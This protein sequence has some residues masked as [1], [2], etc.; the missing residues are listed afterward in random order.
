MIPF[1]RILLAGGT[2]ASAV[3]IGFVM[4]NFSP[5][6]PGSA[7]VQTAV[8][9]Q[10]VT[11]GVAVSTMIGN[12]AAMRPVIDATHTADPMDVTDIELT[13]GDLPE[14]KPVTG[15]GE[16]PV[17]LATLEN[18]ADQL[19]AAPSSLVATCDATMEAAPT[20]AAMVELALSSCLPNTRV[21]LHHNGLMATYVTGASG[22]LDVTLPALSQQAL[23]L[24][25]FPDGTGAVASTTV[26]DIADYDRVAVQW[27]GDEGFQ[28]HAREFDADYGEEGHVWS[29]ATGSLGHAVSGNSGVL[30]RLGDFDTAETLR[31]EVYTFP[32]NSAARDGEIA[33]SVEAELTEANCGR[34]IE[35]QSLQLQGGGA[36]SVRD[37]T[38]QVPSCDGQGGF[39]VLKN[40]LQ[41]LKIARN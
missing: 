15:G 38:L 26:S 25:A 40:L 27:Q 23:F 24:A 4:Q 21:T 30:T 19:T 14:T 2:V 16:T 9:H 6:G 29:G 7:P 39:L 36:L 41:D 10:S 5:T 11:G 35:A 12:R 8:V 1:N 31:A 34:E 20:A 33:L 22:D 13:A 17:V 32:T 3:G 37:L 28:L 18:D